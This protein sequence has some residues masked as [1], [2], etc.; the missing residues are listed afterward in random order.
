MAC[1]EQRRPATAAPQAARPIGAIL[2]GHVGDTLGRSRALTLGILL[3]GCS[4]MAIGCVLRACCQSDRFKLVGRLVGRRAVPKG[5][6][7][8]C[9]PCLLLTA[10]C[11]PPTTRA[12]TQQ[13]PPPPCCS[14]SSASS[15]W[16][17]PLGGELRASRLPMPACLPTP[18]HAVP[19][20]TPTFWSRGWPWVESTG[21]RLFTRAKWWRSSA[22]RS[23]W[24]SCSPPS[25]S[26]WASPSRSSW[27]CR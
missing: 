2:F 16:V 3:M 8:P 27:C 14:A 23:W 18:Q 15:R 22:A 6:C 24:R 20:P 13:A 11:S 12:R 19:P 10:E 21:R 5:L 4:T 17:Q 7:L 9:P 1:S 26:G 25:T